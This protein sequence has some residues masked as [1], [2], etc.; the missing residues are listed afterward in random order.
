MEGE[1]RESREE[2]RKNTDDKRAAW[3]LALSLVLNVMFVFQ[4]TYVIKT[5]KGLTNGN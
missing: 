4:V 3:C 1:E 2:K 5:R